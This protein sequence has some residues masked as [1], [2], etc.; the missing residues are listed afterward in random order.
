MGNLGYWQ[1]IFR[2]L[3]RVDNTNIAGFVFAVFA[4]VCTCAGW[5]WVCFR[6]G[7]ASWKANIVSF[8]KRLGINFEWIPLL[9][10][11]VVAS[12]ILAGAVFALSL[13]LCSTIKVR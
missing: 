12:I 5:Y 10:L 3:E 6:N 13:A 1:P 7:A 8:N 2:L 11:K 9:L 4:L